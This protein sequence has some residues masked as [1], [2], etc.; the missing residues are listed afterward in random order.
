[1]LDAELLTKIDAVARILRESRQVMGGIQLIFCGDFPQL[2]P[3]NG[4]D[5]AFSS[6]VWTEANFRVVYNRGV[7]RQVAGPFMN[8]LQEVREGQLS[9]LGRSLLLSRETSP[10]AINDCSANGV[11]VVPPILVATHLRADS[12]NSRLFDTLG[13]EMKRFEAV[14]TEGAS[15]SLREPARATL[16][17]KVG[18]Q[19]MLTRNLTFT[20]QS[21]SVLL[22]NGQLGI[23]ARW[24]DDGFPVID[25]TFT[26]GSSPTRMLFK[27]PRVTHDVYVGESL[28]TR[29]QLPLQQAWAV[30]IHKSQGSTYDKLVVDLKGTWAEGQVYVALSRVH[31]LDGLYLLGV[32]SAT[33]RADEEALRFDRAMLAADTARRQQPQAF[34]AVA[35]PVRVVRPVQTAASRH[36]A[37]NCAA[38]RRP[39]AVEATEAAS[40]VGNQDESLDLAPLSPETPGGFVARRIDGSRVIHTLVSKVEP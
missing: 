40:G 26:Q 1:M 11:S 12:F 17:L 16:D 39:Q 25:C 6:Q 20:A 2:P 32:N 19:V 10:S 18:T 31:S 8:L 28:W 14:D 21:G 29:E 7:H 30:T 24:T 4:A 23:V 3:V 38:R 5:K 9:E 15:F 13:G 34:A 22:T 35:S 33:I 37:G 36:T 27:V